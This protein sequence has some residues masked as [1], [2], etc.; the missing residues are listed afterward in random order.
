ML[1]STPLLAIDDRDYVDRVDGGWN[2]PYSTRRRSLSAIFWVCYRNDDLQQPIGRGYP[3]KVSA[4]RLS[5]R[6][7]SSPL[8]GV[9]SLSVRNEIAA[10][11]PQIDHEER[12][13]DH[14]LRLIR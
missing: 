10:R 1:R 14:R 8:R 4:N 12:R 6:N 7:L 5:V 2:K 9:L 13:S 11:A 3:S